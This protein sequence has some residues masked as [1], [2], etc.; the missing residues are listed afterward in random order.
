MNITIFGANGGIRKIA[1]DLTP[2]APKWTVKEKHNR[3][4]ICALAFF[5]VILCT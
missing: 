5:L 4:F 2:C 1:V 3:F